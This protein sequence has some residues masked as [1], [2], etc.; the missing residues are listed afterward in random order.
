MTTRLWHEAE[1]MRTSRCVFINHIDREE[2][3]LMLLWRNFML[4][5]ALV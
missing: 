3:I 2:L 1:V 4:V 5:L